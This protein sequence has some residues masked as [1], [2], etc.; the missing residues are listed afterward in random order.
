M[1][2]QIGSS[3]DSAAERAHRPHRHPRAII[4][5]T[6]RRSRPEPSSHAQRQG[7]RSR[8]AKEELLEFRG[9]VSE[10]LSN[11][12]FHVKLE[13][14]HEIITHTSGKMRKNRMRVSAGDK[15]FVEMTPYDLAKGRMAFR[16]R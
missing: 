2:L 14:D 9:V 7:V 4:V 3:G 16:V 5:D 8:V 15:V 12:M 13:H 11:A 10:V 1:A 6:E